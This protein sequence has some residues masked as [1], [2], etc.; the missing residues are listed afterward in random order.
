MKGI[1][2]KDLG[3]LILE[4]GINTLSFFSSLVRLNDKI[5]YLEEANLD[6]KEEKNFY[7]LTYSFKNYSLKS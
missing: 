2:Q 3:G 5:L 6:I 7:I 4:G 1:L